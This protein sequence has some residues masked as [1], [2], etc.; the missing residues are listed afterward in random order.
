MTNSWIL[1]S[2]GEFN[3]TKKLFSY[4]RFGVHTLPLFEDPAIAKVFIDKLHDMYKAKSKFQLCYCTNKQ[5]LKDI[6]DLITIASWDLNQI[7]IDPEFS[8]ANTPE[9]FSIGERVIKIND[10]RDSLNL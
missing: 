10:F 2:Y 8:Q 1:I 3:K 9:R 4:D 7:I 6:L 5:H